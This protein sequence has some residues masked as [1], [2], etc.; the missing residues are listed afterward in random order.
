VARQLPDLLESNLLGE[1][2]GRDSLNAVAWTAAV[3]EARDPQASMVVLT[4][5]HVI[6]PVDLFISRIDT[7]FALAEAQPERLVTFGVIPTEPNTGYG[8]LH[9]G[10]QIPAFEGACEVLEFKEKPDSATA[11]A[12]VDSGEYWWNSGMFVWRAATLMAQLEALKPQTASL[13]RA[14]VA[15]P[16]RLGELFATLEKTSIDYAIMEPVSRGLGSARVAAVSLP[17][18]WRDVGSFSELARVLPQ[19]ERGN[20]V[21]GRVELGHGVNRCLLINAD[22]TGVL[23]VSDIDEMAVIRTGEATLTIPLAASQRVKQLAER[24]VASSSSE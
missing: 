3:L 20:A 1:P 12:Y 17:I 5:D 14:I 16:D 23:A 4:A 7:G 11:A 19:D 10:E 8:Y 9:R 22:P 18:D 2:Q 24:V 13:I 21:R 15:D 6:E